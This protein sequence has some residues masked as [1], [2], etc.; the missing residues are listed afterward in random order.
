MF[1]VSGFMR[2]GRTK[3]LSFILIFSMLLSVSLI[4]PIKMVNKKYMIPLMD[5]YR[6][7]TMVKENK[8]FYVG[9]LL[10][11]YSLK[12]YYMEYNFTDVHGYYLFDI[13]DSDVEKLIK[14]SV[15]YDRFDV[16]APVELSNYEKYRNRLNKYGIKLHFEN[17]GS[18]LPVYDDVT[19]IGYEYDEILFL[20]PNFSYTT[21]LANEYKFIRCERSYGKCNSTL[22]VNGTNEVEDQVYGWN[23]RLNLK[24]NVIERT[25]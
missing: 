4:N 7:A 3:I 14:I 22:F 11:A 21:G 1:V 13:D 6:T 18:L 10:T 5:S 23:F 8:S 2:Y 9:E 24:T 17:E 19:F 15:A 16:Y 25:N 20:K 12:R